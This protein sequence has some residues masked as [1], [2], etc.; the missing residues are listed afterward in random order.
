M[1]TRCMLASGMAVWTVVGL[2][3][4]PLHAANESAVPA[5]SVV[6]SGLVPE[7]AFVAVHLHPRRVLASESLAKLGINELF[8]DMVKETGF[9]PLDL[10]QV[11]LLVGPT[12]AANPP[13]HSGEPKIAIIG[14]FTKPHDAAAMAAKWL[15]G[16]KVEEFE[17][18]GH[19]CFRAEKQPNRFGPRDEPNLCFLDGRTF[20]M[21]SEAWLP[22]VLAAKH[23][24]SPLISA[25]A[26][27]NRG[28]DGTFVF[29]NTDAAKEMFAEIPARTLEGPMKAILDLAGLLQTAR[30]SVFTDPEISLKFTLVGKDEASAAKIAQTIKSLQ[31]MAQALLPMLKSAPGDEN[32]PEDQRESRE[33]AASL[34]TKLVDGLVPHQKGEQ[35]TVE[36]GN[37]GTV[38]S[39]VGKLLLPEINAERLATQRRMRTSNLRQLGLAML[40]YETAYNHFP[41]HAIYS[42]E[43]KPLLSWRVSVLPYLDQQELY[44]QFHLDEPWDSEHNKPLIA[45]IPPIFCSGNKLQ[46]VEGKT[47]YVVPVGKDTI[48]DGDK[49]TTMAMIT[50]GT[51]NTLM[52]LEVGADKAVTWTK[53]D[54][55]EFDPKKPLAGLGR[56]DQGGIPAEF[57][58]GHAQILR[59]NIDAETFRRLILR[60]DGLIVDQSKL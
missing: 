47:T 8:D 34:A 14:R 57:A 1:S 16:R 44:K 43:G 6:Y 53:P 36:I 18:A 37:L 55:M 29:A 52:I 58:D 31:Q 41:A 22:D 4:P 3:S 13:R 15:R 10:D 17:I 60:N 50:D 24:T 30:L 42:K 54:D 45:K 11:A 39:I 28:A 21:V 2:L 26:A 20:A 48:C 7:D 38:D 5:E 9:S 32:I 51:S 49:G 46:V 35:V 59:K 23:A 56:I 19:K 27:S 33:Y 12:I 40:N 25:L